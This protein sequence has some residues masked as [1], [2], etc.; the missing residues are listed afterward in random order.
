M[1]TEIW[2]P[3]KCGEDGMKKLKKRCEPSSVRLALGH[4]SLAAD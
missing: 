3:G 1:H 4:P 2:V